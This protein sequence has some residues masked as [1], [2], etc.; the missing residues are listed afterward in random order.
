MS[1]DHPTLHLY[2]PLSSTRLD[3]LAAICKMYV[4]SQNLT[5]KYVFLLE[6]KNP[7]L[8]QVTLDPKGVYLPNSIEIH[9]SAQT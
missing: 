7:Y 1:Q 4:S 5:P 6:V 9:R 3:G 2:L 8:T